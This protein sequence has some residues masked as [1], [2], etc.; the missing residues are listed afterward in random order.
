MTKKSFNEIRIV[1]ITEF[2]RGQASRIFRELEKDEEIVVMR[3]NKPIA[4]I[5]SFNRKRI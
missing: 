2:N 1:P 4:V 5:K 3:N